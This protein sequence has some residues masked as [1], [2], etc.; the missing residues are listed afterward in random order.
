MTHRTVYSPFITGRYE[1]KN[2][3]KPN[4]IISTRTNPESGRESSLRIL[5]VSR[6][7]D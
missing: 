2:L 6:R 5:R 3:L 7:H 1:Y 4:E